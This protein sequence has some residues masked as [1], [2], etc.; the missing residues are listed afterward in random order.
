MFD[1]AIVGAGP[2]G[3]WCATR[4]AADGVRVALVDGS[5]PR[6]KPCGGGVTGRALES[7]MDRGGFPGVGRPLGSDPAGPK[8]STSAGGFGRT[9]DAVRFE[10]SAAATTVDLPPGY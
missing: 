4:L 1:V 6:E 5:H 8:A 2:A 10:T 7:I 3:A 9:I